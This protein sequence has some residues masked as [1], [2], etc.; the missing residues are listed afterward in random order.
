[1][2]KVGFRN[3]SIEKIRKR[4]SKKELFEFVVSADYG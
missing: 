1:M 3:V 2:L 4:N